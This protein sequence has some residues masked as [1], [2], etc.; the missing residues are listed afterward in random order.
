MDEQTL[1]MSRDRDTVEAP[2]Y[3]TR[4]HHFTPVQLRFSDLDPLNHVN[5]SVYQELY[6][7]GRLVFLHDHFD[8]IPQWNGHSIVIIRLD[9]DF[10]RALFYGI[11]PR[12]ATRI[13]GYDDRLVRME[14]LLLSGDGESTIVHS[15]CE[16]L[17]VGYDGTTGHSTELLPEW[18]EQMEKSMNP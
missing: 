18:K 1:L 8:P 11:R 13:A 3:R 12:V 6:D 17:L 10:Y 14:Q 5:N 15:R 16:T 9:L 2:D 4:F 7:V